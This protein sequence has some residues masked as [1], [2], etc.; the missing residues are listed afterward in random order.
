M[1]IHEHKNKKAFLEGIFTN[2]V[3]LHTLKRT[4]FFSTVTVHKNTVR[5]IPGNYRV[6]RARN[7]SSLGQGINVGP[8][9]VCKKNE[10][11]ASEL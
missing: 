8:G 11:R 4:V 1:K 9:K 7:R 2:C 6:C 10:R 3:Y 5:L